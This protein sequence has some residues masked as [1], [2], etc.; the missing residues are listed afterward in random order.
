MQLRRLRCGQPREKSNLAD[1][2]ALC[3][4]A[5]R[6]FE[7][8]LCT[9]KRP[10]STMKKLSAG[11]ASRT[12]TSPRL[13]TRRSDS[14]VSA[15]S[16]INDARSNI[17]VADNNLAAREST[18]DIGPDPSGRVLPDD[19]ATCSQSFWQSRVHTGDVPFRQ[20]WPR[21]PRRECCQ[22]ALSAKTG[23]RYQDV[24]PYLFGQ[25]HAVRSVEEGGNASRRFDFFSAGDPIAGNIYF[26]DQAP[27]GVVVTTGPLTSVKEQAAGAYA[28]AMA[29]RGYAALAFDHRTFG[30]SGGS[31]RQLE[32]PQGKA[33]DICQ[34]CHRAGGAAR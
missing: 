17:N 24:P 18:E 22:V 33:D 5:T 1:E 31:P 8:P 10:D 34:R 20:C 21:L 11:S 25:I 23:L 19:C 27:K 2:L 29:E 3:D 12:R 15:S 9:V 7:F 32:D 4:S 30:E 28:K 14:A 13:R 6:S 26:P 16:D